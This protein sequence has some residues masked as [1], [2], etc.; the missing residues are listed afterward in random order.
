MKPF[1]RKLLRS[2]GLDSYLHGYFSNIINTRQL[3]HILRQVGADLVFDIGA[4]QGQ[5]AQS[6]L[7]E[8]FGG[9]VVSFEPLSEAHRQLAVATRQFPNWIA[10]DRCAIGDCD[11]NVDINVSMNSASSSILGMLD[12]HRSAA[13]ESAYVSSESVP[14]VKLDSI[15]PLYAKSGSQIFLKIDTQGYEWQVLDGAS[16]ML[17][18]VKGI[19]CELSL[20]ELYQGQRLWLDIIKRLEREGFVLWSLQQGFTDNRSSRTLQLDA[21]FLRR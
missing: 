15:L 20:V 21:I 14:I 10:H 19:L 5:F 3:A 7:I 17:P 11:G 6:L 12:A 13:N 4:N 18:V 2:T 16:H 1:L 8:G 9:K